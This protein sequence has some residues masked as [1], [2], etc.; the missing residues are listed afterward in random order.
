MHYAD[1]GIIPRSISYIFNEVTK[2]S[3][4]QIS[5]SVPMFSCCLH[6]C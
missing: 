6:V 2:R 1:R 5:V 4:H 3:D